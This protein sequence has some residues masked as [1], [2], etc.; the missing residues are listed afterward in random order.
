MTFQST[1]GTFKLSADVTQGGS[2]F[3]SL[4]AVTQKARDAVTVSKRD[5]T[6]KRSRSDERRERTG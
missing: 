6:T 2:V 1:L 3:H 5:G 4:G